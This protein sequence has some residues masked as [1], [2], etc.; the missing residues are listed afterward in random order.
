MKQS[1][2][3]Y[4]CMNMD[5]EPS[6]FKTCRID[7]VSD[8]KLTELIEHNLKV[9][10]SMIDFNIKHKNHMYRV[11]SSLIPFGSSPLNTLMWDVLFKEDFERIRGKIKK[12][13]IRISCHPGQYTVINSNDSKVVANSIQE[14]EYHA[15]MMDLLSGD[16]SHKMILHVGGIYG[17]KEAAIKRFIEVYNTILP[18]NVK[19][20]LVI[21][22]D[23]RLYTVADVL[24][25]AKQTSVPVVFD[26]LHHQCNP[27]LEKESLNQVIEKVIATW[28]KDVKPKMH[29]SQQDPGKRMGAHSSTIDLRLFMKDYEDVYGL[30]PLDIMLEVKDK[31]RSF[32][33]VDLCLNY[34]KHVLEQE[35]ARYKYLIMAHSMPAYNKVRGMFKNDQVVN[36]VEFYEAIDETLKI[37]ATPRSHINAMDHVWGYFKKQCTP[38]ELKSYLDK[39]E[40]FRNQDT[41]HKPVIRHLSKLAQ[42][43]EKGYLLQSYYFK[44]S[45]NS[46]T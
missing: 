6:V 40:S 25:I 29:Y 33:K 2:I 30:Y 3:G 14:L 42:K 20:Y 24:Y 41:D 43:Y 37:E 23:D 15:K 44:A 22:N 35:W 5:T 36:V 13:S 9:L 34:N 45:I 11:S 38:L 19:K 18:D 4:A 31:N 7:N 1:E 21:E 8:D 10:E 46:R 39:R 17:D 26:N 16:K 28:P 27:S 12:G 32:I